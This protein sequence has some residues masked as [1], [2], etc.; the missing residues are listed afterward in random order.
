VSDQAIRTAFRIHP[1]MLG[2]CRRR[3]PRQRRRPPRSRS[4]AGTVAPA[5][6]PLAGHAQQ[7][8][9]PAEVRPDDVGPGV[10]LRQPGGNEDEA[11]DAEIALN[12]ARAAQ[13]LVISGYDGVEAAAAV[14]LPEMKWTRS[15]S[16][17]ATRRR[18]G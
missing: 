2:D 10:R 14:G 11:Q 1:H 12:R 8:P 5:R 13:F 17:T 9:L 6:E 3:E 16:F 7:R 15:E 4:R 18:P